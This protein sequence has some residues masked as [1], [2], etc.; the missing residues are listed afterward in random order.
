MAVGE[1]VVLLRNLWKI[2]KMG[3]ASV[4][5]LRGV[6]LRV[7]RGGYVA[8]LGPSGSGKSTLLNI[9]GG[10]DRPTEGLVYVNGENLRRLSESQ[11]A[12][13]RAK[14]VG[15][16]FQFFNLIPTFTVL[17]NV[18][19]PA[20][21]LGLNR[22]EAR[23]RAE[24]I[25]RIVGLEDR[26]HSFPSQLSGGEQQRAAIA[27][28]FVNEPALLLCDEPTGNLDTKTG[29]GIVRLLTE[30]NKRYGITL[31]VVTHDDRIA[32]SADRVVNL[33]DGKIV[34]EYICS[35]F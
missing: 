7:K 12:L 26:I 34:G 35:H 15:F 25:L 23:R 30:A 8:V 3:E 5:A 14:N 16:V 6:D 18:M 24:I 1:S 17:E 33:I 2:Y 20:E 4:Q 10:L 29:A 11:L 21:I 27:R 32:N 13:F 9:I 22:D 28:A 31:I 19:V